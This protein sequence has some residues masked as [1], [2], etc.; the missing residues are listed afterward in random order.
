V[1]SCKQYSIFRQILARS[2]WGFSDR[3]LGGTDPDR[4]L[5]IVD[6]ILE[7]RGK[8][9]KIPALWDGKAAKRI[10][11]IIDFPAGCLSGSFRVLLSAR[12]IVL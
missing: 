6:D 4:I 5:T 2:L 1:F 10:V 9:G 11:D 3:L 12:L 7:G 8:K